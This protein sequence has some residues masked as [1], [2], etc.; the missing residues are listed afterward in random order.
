MDFKLTEV[1]K[2]FCEEYDGELD[3]YGSYSGRCMYGRNCPGIVL[4]T[5]E[6]YMTPLDVAV[7]LAD[8]IRDE[9]EDNANELLGSICMDNLGLDTIIYFPDYDI[10]AEEDDDDEV[11]EGDE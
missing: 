6:S 11:E 1:L 10:D 9:G 8:Y 3:Y 2:N 5:S 7:R 4:K